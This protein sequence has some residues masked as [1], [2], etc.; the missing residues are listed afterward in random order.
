MNKK[1]LLISLIVLVIF[2]V[3]L[4]TIVFSAYKYDWSVGLPAALVNWKIITLKDLQEDVKSVKQFY[5]TQAEIDFSTSEGKKEYAVL[6]KA[7]L[8]QIIE[9]K[10]IRSLAKDY[11]LKIT[12]QMVEEEVER[13][14]AEVG[15]RE[16]ILETLQELY[17]WDL[18]DFKK[19][20]A[21]PQMYKEALER[22]INQDFDQWLEGQKKQ[23]KIYVFYPSYQWD[24]QEGRL[25]FIDEELRRYE[26]ETQ[27]LEDSYYSD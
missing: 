6:K 8:A 15:N 5:E 9:N 23:A 24:K 27:E 12:E 11:N 16:Q 7:V 21:K 25:V 3:S 14:I 13:V 2:L 4:V 17:D 26:E 18:D 19:R 10:L 1:N 20:V 22:E